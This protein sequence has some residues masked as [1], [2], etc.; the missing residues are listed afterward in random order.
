VGSAAA[1]LL[2]FGFESRLWHEC[3]SLLSVVHCQVEVSALG[4]SVVQRT[5]TKFGVSECDNEASIK[6][7]PWPTRGFCVMENNLYRTVTLEGYFRVKT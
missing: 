1:H 3:L 6:R 4:C 2:R 7:R 5:P